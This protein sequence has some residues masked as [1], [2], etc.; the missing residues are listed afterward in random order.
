MHAKSHDVLNDVLSLS[1]ASCTQQVKQTPLSS[2]RCPDKLKCRCCHCVSC[3]NSI[4]V[5]ICTNCPFVRHVTDQHR[6]Y[7]LNSTCSMTMGK[8]IIG[9]KTRY[10]A[11]TRYKSFISKIWNL[12]GQYRCLEVSRML[13]QPVSVFKYITILNPRSKCIRFRRRYYRLP[14]TLIKTIL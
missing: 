9:D 8:R 4:C 1:Q 3:N 11:D 6:L 7:S 12:Y 10:N 13:Y 2:L 5:L 14:R